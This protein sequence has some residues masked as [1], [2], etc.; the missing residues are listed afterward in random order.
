MAKSSV[1]MK[2]YVVDEGESVP[3][4]EPAP[5]LVWLVNRLQIDPEDNTPLM[6]GIF[7]NYNDDI[8]IE[9]DSMTIVGRYDPARG[10]AQRLEIGDGLRV[11]DGVLIGEGG[12]EKGDPGPMGPQGPV[13]PVGPAGASSSMWLYRW[14]SAT[15]GMDPGAGRLRYNNTA[16]SQVTRIYFDRLTQ[17]GLDPTAVFTVAQFDDQ[18]VI[19]RRGMSAQ[20]QQWRL[21]GPAIDRTDW[22]E[23]PVEFVSITGAPFSNNMEI[24]VLLRT[25]GQ[26][27][28]TGPQ[29][30]QGLT[31]NTGPAGPTGPQG[32]IGPTGPQGGTG[33]TGPTGPQ[34]PSGDFGDNEAPVDNKYYARKNATWAEIVSDVTKAYVD[35]EVAKRVAKTGD[36]MTGQL[37]N[38]DSVWVRSTTEP[39]MGV[40]TTSMTHE[41]G[42]WFG[43]GA[44]DLTRW[45]IVLTAGNTLEFKAFSDDG[46]TYLG[47]ALTL[48]RDLRCTFSGPVTLRGNSSWKWDSPGAGAWYDSF[49]TVQA[50]YLG[51]ES[52]GGDFRLYA[53]G[54]GNVLIFNPSTSRL[55][56]HADPTSAFGIATK[57]YV[58]AMPML[59]LAGGVMTGRIEQSTS[60]FKVGYASDILSVRINSGF[61]ENSGSTVATGW[62]TNSDWHHLL[63][64]THSNDAN[65]YSMQISTT[66]FGSDL[67]WR[68][69]Q[70]SGSTGWRTIWDNGNFT[71]SS[72]IS[73]TGDTMTGRFATASGV[74]TGNNAISSGAGGL[75]EIE[76]LGNS[77]GAAM[78][79][80]HRPGSFAAYFG[81][82]TDNVWKV[83]GWSM[84]A[85][86][87]PILLASQE[88]QTQIT[89]GAR[90]AH[91]D[92]GGTVGATVIIDPGVRPMQVLYNNGAGTITHVWYPGQCTIL[93]IN[94][95]GCAPLTLSGWTKVDGALD[96]VS[97]SQFLCSVAIFNGGGVS[98]AVFTILKVW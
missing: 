19:Q 98:T 5:P 78:V 79:A 21:T 14:D 22:F 18:F 53:S 56:V 42:F 94:I 4:V 35:T 7:S 68:S 23:V 28:P 48:S 80:F 47:S 61:Y 85:V 27:G 26:P 54:V 32:P 46:I 75:G 13:G 11:E 89:G 10:P 66:F 44:A 84:G 58:D 6:E 36:T 64:C 17:D 65:Y 63:A 92:L 97:G 20:N 39:W 88:N 16:P 74:T 91:K 8:V 60:G 82:D 59:P 81:V 72:K 2:G 62:P 83:G 73:K 45:G 41:P 43:R 55:T 40:Y 51:T 37:K 9:T 69:T 25:R 57:Q 76:I 67:F 33:M 96:S 90:V 52:S 3:P 49:T 30:P 70:G 86:A 31:G 87:H 50:Y 95:G 93:I 38:E 12:G 15:Q 71:P 77:A 1:R 29:G 34:G 24:T